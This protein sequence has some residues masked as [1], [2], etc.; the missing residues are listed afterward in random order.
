MDGPE[1]YRHAV[2][3]MSEATLAAVA[4]AGLTLDDI[5]LFVYHQANAR[6]HRALGGSASASARARRRLHRDA[7]QLLGRDAAGGAGGAE[8]EGG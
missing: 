2:A 5:D 3:R 1:V 8:R 7:R 6:I 4:R